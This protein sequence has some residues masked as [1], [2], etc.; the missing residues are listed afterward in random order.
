MAEKN[1]RDMSESRK[2]Q[3]A[4]LKGNS[5]KDKPERRWIHGR[6]RKWVSTLKDRGYSIA[7]INDCI[8]NMLAMTREELIEIQKN[9]AS[10]I[11]E[12]NIATAI[13]KDI[14]RGE[15][16]T[17]EMLLSRRFGFPKQQLEHTGEMVTSYEIIAA[18][19]KK[20]T[21]SQ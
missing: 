5:F 14:S 1:Q 18:S 8:Q 4:N 21:D 19:E 16:K 20:E 11:I 15:F 13:I 10:T 9:K 17:A 12:V 6:P 2:K 3:L 7:E